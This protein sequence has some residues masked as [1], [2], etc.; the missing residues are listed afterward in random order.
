MDLISFPPPKRLH[1]KNK[2]H[3]L[4]CTEMESDIQH[5]FWE[6]EQKYAIFTQICYLYPKTAQLVLLFLQLLL[7]LITFSCLAP[8]TLWQ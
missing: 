8:Y 1:K 2:N 3:M 4:A 6:G 7:F 5:D